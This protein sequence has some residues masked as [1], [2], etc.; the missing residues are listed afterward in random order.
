MCTS[1]PDYINQKGA[2]HKLS[3]DTVRLISSTQAVTGV[4]SIV[5]ELLENSLDVD[6]SVIEINIVSNH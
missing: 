5:K 2:M 3:N 6:A 4:A 1:S